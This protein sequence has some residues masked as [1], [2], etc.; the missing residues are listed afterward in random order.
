[1]L[2]GV[3]TLCFRAIRHHGKGFDPLVNSDTLVY[4]IDLNGLHFYNNAKKIAVNAVF[5]DCD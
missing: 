1:M 2:G 5:N 4:G 3:R